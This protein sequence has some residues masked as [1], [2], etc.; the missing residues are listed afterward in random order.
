[1]ADSANTTTLSAVDPWISLAEAAGVSL[2]R[3]AA[4]K[5]AARDSDG[6]YVV[7]GCLSIAEA[8]RL[9]CEDKGITA[10]NG[11]SC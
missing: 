1:M 9:F 8:A 4:G 11:G 10:A 5:Y 3:T 6:V 2:I 7:R